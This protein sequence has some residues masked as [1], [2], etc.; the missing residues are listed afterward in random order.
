LVGF[1]KLGGVRYS[2]IT[3]SFRSFLFDIKHHLLPLG[4]P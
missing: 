1:C 4:S 2:M 3:R